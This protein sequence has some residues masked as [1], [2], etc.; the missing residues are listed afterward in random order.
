MDKDLNKLIWLVLPVVIF[1]VPYLSRVNGTGADLFLYGENGWIEI[2]TVVF[3]FIAIFFGVLFLLLCRVQGHGWLQWW[4]ALLVLGS[5][6]FAGEEISWG[7]H[8]FGWETSSYWQ[9]LN[10]QGETNLHNIG[11][12]FDQI[13]RTLLS[14]A[15]LVG[16]VLVPLY[17]SLSKRH[18]SVTSLHYWLWP[19][20]VCVPAA[21]FS[22]LVSWH[23]KMYGILGAEIPTV[24]DVRAGEVKESLLALFIMVYVM[25]VWYRARKLSR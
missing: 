5:I 13:P 3:L 9:S 19:T 25:S 20:Y 8:I 6:Y 12:L 18:P 7:Q 1:L 21:L 4:M 16:G 15:A 10:D 17:Y 2:L 14:A 23:E 11:P 22:M 24:L